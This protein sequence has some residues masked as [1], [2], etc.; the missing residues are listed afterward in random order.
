MVWKPVVTLNEGDL[1]E[2]VLRLWQKVQARG[3]RPDLVVGIATGGLVCARYLQAEVAVLPV[4]LRRHGTTAKGRPVVA[5][6]LR[7]APYPLTD[8]LRRAEDFVLAHR[9]GAVPQDGRMPFAEIG[10]EVADIAAFVRDRQARRVLVMDDAADSGATLRCVLSALDAALPAEVEVLTAV[11]AQTR[12]DAKVR[13]D[14]ALYEGVLC[15]FPW[16]FDYR[17]A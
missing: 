8:M 3:A 15:R 6:L 2:A 16:S 4:T 9:A 12:A 11:I 7:R 5:G 1:R 17:G 14:V 13:A 10:A